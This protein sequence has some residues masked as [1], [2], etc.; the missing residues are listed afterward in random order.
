[1]INK[2]N[3]L[4]AWCWKWHVIAGLI[5]LP[6]VLLLSVTGALYLLKQDYENLIYSDI[7]YVTEQGQALSLTS[8]LALAR[9]SSEGKI[10]GLVLPQANNQATEF[11]LAGKG[12]ATNVLYLNPYTGEIIGRINQRDTLMCKI[13]KLHGELL[14]DTPGTLIIEL[15]ASWFIVL[16]MT[17]IYI[18][19]PK[20]GTGVAGIFTI[21]TGRSRRLFWRDLHAVIGFWLSVFMLIIIAGGMPWTDVFGSQLKWVQKQTGTGYPGHWR[22]AKGL[23]SVRDVGGQS[24]EGLNLDA[25]VNQTRNYAL[26]GKITINLPQGEQGVFTVS[27]RSVWLSDQQ[28]IHID[29]YSGQAVKHLT[30]SDVGILMDLRQVFMRLHQGE[31]GSWNWWLLLSV[32]LL[33]TF[34][35]FAGLISYVKRKPVDEWGIPRVPD[36]FHVSKPLIGLVVFLGLLFPMFGISI[37]VIVSMQKISLPRSA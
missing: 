13:R 27:N 30:W 15:V 18:W 37:V 20:P 31:Y 21:R 25:I 14:L 3:K 26:P 9:Q 5:T 11:H 17:G 4:N 2:S 23:S 35:T 34:S 10:K 6:F 1:M 16:L 28:V 29:R 8:Q 12:R 36:A 7:K 22:S 19:W 32:A 24:G 33:F